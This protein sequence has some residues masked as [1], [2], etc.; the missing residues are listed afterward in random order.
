MGNSP[1]EKRSLGELVDI[2][3]RA[4]YTVSHNILLDKQMNY[5]VDMWT[6]RRIENWLNCWAQRAVTSSMEAT[7]WLVTIGVPQ[8]SILNPV[9]CNVFINDLADGTK[10][11]FI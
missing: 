6:V 8:G 10:Y 3:A 11:T 7:A 4:F 5:K 1:G 9:L 2:P